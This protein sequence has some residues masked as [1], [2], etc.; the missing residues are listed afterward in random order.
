MSLVSISCGKDDEIGFPVIL[1]PSEVINVSNIRMFTNK[2][3]IYDTE[4]INQ[5]IH[6]S[7]IVLPDVPDESD[8]ND[9]LA[10]IHF[11]SKDSVSFGSE[12]FVLR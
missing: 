11:F 2:E 9:P 8:L 3:E 10:I 6:H 7:N 12:T 1:H 4:K 5:F